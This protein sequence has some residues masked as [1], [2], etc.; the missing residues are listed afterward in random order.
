MPKPPLNPWKQFGLFRKQICAGV[1]DPL[2]DVESTIREDVADGFRRIKEESFK[3]Y[4]EAYGRD[5]AKQLESVLEKYDDFARSQFT[6]AALLGLAKNHLPGAA[7]IAKPYPS[8]T[9]AS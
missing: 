5:A 6:E 4:E 7:E 3:R 2:P 1:H 8:A 9:T